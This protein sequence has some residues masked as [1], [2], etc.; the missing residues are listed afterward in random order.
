[1]NRSSS[2][3]WPATSSSLR[4]TVRSRIGSWAFKI[5][6]MPPWANFP[7]MSL[8]VRRSGSGRGRRPAR[9]PGGAAGSCRSGRRRG[10]RLDAGRSRRPCR[11]SRRRGRGRRRTIWALV[12]VQQR[13]S[14]GDRA[15]LDAGAGGEVGELLEGG[16]ELGAAV[17]VAG[18]VEGVDAEPDLARAEGL[19][20]AERVGE[21]QGV[22]GGDVGAGDRAPRR[23]RRPA[24]RRARC[25]APARSRWRPAADVGEVDDLVGAGAEAAGLAAGALELDLVALAVAEAQRVG[26]AVLG[27]GER[28]DGGRVEAAA[29][30]D[31]GAGAFGHV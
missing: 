29:E 18:V 3:W 9:S 10:P 5:R 23:G 7:S 28:E 13:A 25:R 30:E 6:P 19:G 22:A 12:Q 27:G 16:D 1:M 14:E 21:E 15:A 17:G 24:G 20:P 2:T 8:R 31:D 26:L 4:A 11:R